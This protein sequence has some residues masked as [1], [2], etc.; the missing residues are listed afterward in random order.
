MTTAVKVDV[1]IQVDSCHLCDDALRGQPLLEVLLQGLSV[2]V[3]ARA[4]EK[5]VLHVF[6]SRLVGGT[7]RV[8]PKWCRYA[9]MAPC[10][11]GSCAR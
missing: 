11:V 8:I 9:V 7:R 5:D 4:V 6:L 3:E 1:A 10:P 2:L